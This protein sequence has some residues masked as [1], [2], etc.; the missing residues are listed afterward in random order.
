MSTAFCSPNW[1]SGHSRTEGSE[2]IVWLTPECSS[3]ARTLVLFAQFRERFP[4]SVTDAMLGDLRR[5]YARMA[6]MI[7]AAPPDFDGAITSVAALE[8]ELNR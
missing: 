4:M 2:R 6:G 1:G 3:T 8:N 7:I 5:D